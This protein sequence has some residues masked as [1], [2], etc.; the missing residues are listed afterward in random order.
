MPSFAATPIAASRGRVRQRWRLL[1]QTSFF[2]LFCVAPAFDLLRFDLN[3]GH[4][5]FLGMPWRAGLDLYARGEISTWEAGANLVF[6][7]FLPLALV[8]AALLYAAWRWGRLYCGWLCP[9][10]SAV[11][12]INRMMRL[13]SGK[14]SIWDR[15][16][17]PPHEPDGSP[18]ARKVW[19]W[20]PTL[21]MAA[22]LAFVWSVVFLT[23]LLPPFEIYGNLL[24]GTLTANQSAFVAAGTAAFTLEFL[25]ARH[26]F[27]QYGCAIGVFQSLAWMLNPKGMVVGF[28]RR[29]AADCAPCASA[30]E[31]VCPMRLKPRSLKRKMFTCTQCAQCVSACATTQADN[32]DGPLLSWIAG[33]A[34][35]ENEA[36]LRSGLKTGR[37]GAERFAPRK[38]R[39]G[40]VAFG[41]DPD[42][43]PS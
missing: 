41:T 9:H 42:R 11:E 38:L 18:V 23:Y 28:T 20:I 2:V 13:A 33:E 5:W 3:A 12:T 15:A 32:P 43:L 31:H 39:G 24:A 36:G 27:C 21:L 29:R 14:F 8:A 6:I 19:W 35:R 17:L 25:F 10:F 34:A 22:G 4:A 26:L 16:T 7:V 1:A 40:F 37:S 30:C